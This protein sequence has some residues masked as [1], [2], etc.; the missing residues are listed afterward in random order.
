MQI[1]L[2]DKKGPCVTRMIRTYYL[3][4]IFMRNFMLE[5]MQGIMH[6]AIGI[7]HLSCKHFLNKSTPHFPLYAL[8]KLYRP[9]TLSAL[10]QEG[11]IHW[12]NCSNCSNSA[13]MFFSIGYGLL[14][15]SVLIGQQSC[16]RVV[17]TRGS[18]LFDRYTLLF[19][20]DRL[21]LNN[22]SKRAFKDRDSIC[23]F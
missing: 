13:L 9:P 15:F 11:T 3:Y 4:D 20:F 14:C 18:G 16:S 19:R 7:I 8:F 21:K 1:N 10:V 23:L 22:C 2:T 5:T 6:R 17:S 12:V